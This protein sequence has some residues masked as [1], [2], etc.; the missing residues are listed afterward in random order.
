MRHKS[1][2][3]HCFSLKHQKTEGNFGSRMQ[4]GRFAFPHTPLSS[5]FPKDPM[6]RDYTANARLL[7]G[8]QCVLE[9]PK[10]PPVQV[11]LLHYR[12]TSP[13]AGHL[14]DTSQLPG[15]EHFGPLAS[16]SLGEKEGPSG[17]GWRSVGTAASG[18]WG[19]PGRA[20]ARRAA[21]PLGGRRRR[22]L[23][24]AGRGGTSGPAG[25]LP[26]EASGQQSPPPGWPR[27]GAAAAARPLGTWSGPAAGEA[28]A[29]R[30]RRQTPLSHGPGPPRRR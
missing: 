24:L 21:G 25:K 29:E 13:G 1:Q 9:D 28:G 27:A 3:C 19:A 5:N 18:H 6:G 26:M 20:R 23:A 10:H 7:K 2:D 12:G 11:Y 17:G 15:A 8:A 14:T 4:E 30:P 22:S 16:P